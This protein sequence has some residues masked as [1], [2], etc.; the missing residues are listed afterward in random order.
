MERELIL[1]RIGPRRSRHH[2][3]KSYEEDALINQTAGLTPNE[4]LWH[5]PQNSKI[6]FQSKNFDFRPPGKLLG[7]PS[8]Q[9]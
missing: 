7:F 6:K 5:R 4:T 9:A 1:T 2:L 8:S 3:S